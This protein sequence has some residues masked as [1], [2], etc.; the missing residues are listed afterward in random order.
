MSIPNAVI[1]AVTFY[2]ADV[3]ATRQLTQ[4]APAPSPAAAVPPAGPAGL[5][6]LHFLCPYSSPSSPISRCSPNPQCDCSSQ[7]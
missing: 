3:I 4:I 2:G 5:P 7:S 6:F 1:E